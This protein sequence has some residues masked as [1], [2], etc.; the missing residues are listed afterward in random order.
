MGFIALLLGSVLGAGLMYFLDPNAGKKR[1]EMAREQVEKL[2]DTASRE[3]RVLA[4]NAAKKARNA[5]EWVEAARAD[6]A[7]RRGRPAEHRSADQKGPAQERGE[8]GDG[9]NQREHAPKVPAGRCCFKC[10][11]AALHYRRTV[12]H[13]QR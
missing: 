12:T 1:R 10:T 4:E 7:I 8:R 9:A 5:A 6:A 3:A 13:S 11:R 2:R